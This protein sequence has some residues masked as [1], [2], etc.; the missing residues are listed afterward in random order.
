LTITAE[1]D[2][3]VVEWRV[4]KHQEMELSAISELDEDAGL[5]EDDD[6]LRMGSW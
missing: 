4:I 3:R 5:E 6:Y 2:Y 1:E